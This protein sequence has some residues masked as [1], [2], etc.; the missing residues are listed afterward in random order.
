M[1]PSHPIQLFL[2]DSYYHIFYVHVNTGN[3]FVA[4]FLNGTNVKTQNMA[5]E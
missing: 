4:S 5:V 3:H 2:S 1:Q